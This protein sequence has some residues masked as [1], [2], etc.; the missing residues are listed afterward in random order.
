MTC[1]P[2][3]AD[4]RLGGCFTEEW[5][6]AG[7]RKPHSTQEGGALSLGLGCLKSARATR[8]TDIGKL[9]DSRDAAIVARH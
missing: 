2:N 9:S 4:P 5:I 3:K 8:D 7:L 6:T 1:E